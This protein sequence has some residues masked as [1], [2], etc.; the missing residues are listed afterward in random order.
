MDKIQITQP[1]ITQLEIDYVNDAVTNGWGAKCYDYIYKFQDAFSNYIGSD[2]CLATSSCTGAIHLGLMA[3]GIK[4]GDEVIVPESTWIASVEPVMYIGAKPVFVDVLKDTWCIDP[5]KIEE[6]ITPKTKAI[7]VVHL[8]GNVCEMDEIMGIA[9][10]HDLKVLEDSAEGLGSEY[11]G[12]KCGAIGDCGVFSFHGTKTMTTGEGGMLVTN[13]KEI[14]EKVSVLNDHGRNPKDPE[15]KTF[16]MRDYGYKYKMAN[17]NAAL[18]LAQISRMDELVEKKRLIFNW[19]KE[20]LS[21]N[22]GIQLNEEQ[23]YAFNSYW[24]PTIV[25]LKPLNIN[26]ELLFSKFQSEN[27]DSRPFFLPLSSLP[28][29]D[30]VKENKISYQIGYNGIN[31]PSH[32]ALKKSEIAAICDVLRKFILTN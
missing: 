20:E 30:S 22:E 25:F 15:N 10:R 16:W 31:L 32:H 27:I 13:N 1:S 6:A 5:K 17:I 8:Y 4:E 19:Y 2:Y 18:G 11:R 7:I 23:E 26:R 29:F 21:G 9:K 3:L 28:M 14:Y 24:M 12:K